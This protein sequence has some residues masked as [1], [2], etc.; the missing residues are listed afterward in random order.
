MADFYLWLGCKRLSLVVR[1]DYK[2]SSEIPG[3]KLA[4][5]IRALVL[6]R[7]PIF[8]HEHTHHART[9]VS[10]GWLGRADNFRVR[11][12]T[13]LSV[14]KA[15]D[16]GDLRAVRTLDASAAAKRIGQGGAI[17]LWLSHGGQVDMYE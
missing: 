6:E 11:V 8:L 5:E 15:L 7:L 16:T 1:E 2:V 13:R 4:I 10:L 17:E 14:V 3:T 12:F 9:A